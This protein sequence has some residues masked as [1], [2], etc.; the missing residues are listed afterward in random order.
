MCKIYPHLEVTT[1]IISDNNFPN[2]R[3][4]ETTLKMWIWQIKIEIILIRQKKNQLESKI[5]L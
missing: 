1:L 3:N 2:W 4:D 5:L